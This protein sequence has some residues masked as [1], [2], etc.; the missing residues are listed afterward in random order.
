MNSDRSAEP[1]CR[2]GG[3]IGVLLNQSVYP[4]IPLYVGT[5]PKTYRITGVAGDITVSQDLPVNVILDGNTSTPTTVT[6]SALAA[7]A[8]QS[9]VSAN[10]I[11]VEGRKIEL[12][13]K[14]VPGGYSG[15]FVQ[16]CFD[17]IQ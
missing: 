10:S 15:K 8:E 2:A 12:N 1:V 16:F 9:G 13:F 4:T 11:D 6:F 7:N 3:T 14:P 17:R 5:V